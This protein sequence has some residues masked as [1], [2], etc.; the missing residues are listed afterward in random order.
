MYASDEFKRSARECS[1]TLDFV[2][3]SIGPDMDV[4]FG[5]LIDM[6]TSSDLFG[7]LRPEHWNVFRESLLFSLKDTLGDRFDDKARASWEKVFDSISAAMKK[8][9]RPSRRASTQ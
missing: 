8:F 9:L 5:Q 2:V 3:T 1:N 6:V 7:R 4:L